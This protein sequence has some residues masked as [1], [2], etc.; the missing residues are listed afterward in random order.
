MGDFCML[1]CYVASCHEM[2][3]N[4][5]SVRVLYEYHQHLLQELLFS[6]TLIFIHA[7]SPNDFHFL[8][9]QSSFYLLLKQLYHT[10]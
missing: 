6:T 4:F 7:H 2:T 5:R 8:P 3:A 1:R 10:S 9:S